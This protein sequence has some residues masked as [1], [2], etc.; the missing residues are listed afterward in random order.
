MM[1]HSGLV[2]NHWE[3]NYALCNLNVNMGSSATFIST[4]IK[5][6]NNKKKTTKQRWGVCIIYE[7]KAPPLKEPLMFLLHHIYTNL[8]PNL[9]STSH[10]S[11]NK[12]M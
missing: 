5:E 3:Q 2:A 4:L 1:N 10:F 11:F 6:K 9:I 7:I 12:V 8:S